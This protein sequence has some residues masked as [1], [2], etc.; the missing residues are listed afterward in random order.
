MA[1]AADDRVKRARYERN[2]TLPRALPAD[3]ENNVFFSLDDDARIIDDL[4]KKHIFVFIRAGVAAGKTTMA[5]YLCRKFKQ[6][7][8]VE[9]PKLNHHL[10]ASWIMS[11]CNAHKKQFPDDQIS[12]TSP[13][14][15]DQVLNS[16]SR[17]QMTLVFDEAHLFFQIKC[18]SIA[19]ALFKTSTSTMGIRVL[20]FSTTGGRNNG[21]GYF[22]PPEIQTRLLWS[23]KI[24]ESDDVVNQ[25]QRC[26]I[27]LDKKSIEFIFNFCGGN[28]GITVKAFTWVETKQESTSWD[29]KTTV[30]NI[31]ASATQGWTSSDFLLA[32]SKSRAVKVNSKYS[33]MSNI[34]K[35]FI[36]VLFQGPRT[37]LDGETLKNLTIA[38]FILPSPF[39]RNGPIS[40]A[41]QGRFIECN[42]WDSREVPFGVS[43]P[44]MAD[45]YR[46]KFA[47]SYVALIDPLYK[48]PQNCLDILVRVVPF[49][50]FKNLFVGHVCM[51][52]KN[53]VSGKVPSKKVPDMSA[54]VFPHETSYGIAIRDQLKKF[55]F[56]LHN[57][58]GVDGQPDIVVTSAQNDQTYII[59]LALAFKKISSIQA[60]LR[61]HL[62]RFCK[63]VNYQDVEGS[64]AL[65]VIGPDEKTILTHLERL[66]KTKQSSE[67]TRIV[68]LVGLC[69]SPAYVSYK[70]YCEQPTGFK[71]LYIPVDYVAR[72]FCKKTQKL[73]CVMNLYERSLR[74]S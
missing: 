7:V 42:F 17:N 6:Y 11:L 16:F 59:E 68:E 14:A 70:V 32:L 53:V 47:N 66:K 22:T 31:C 2:L 43:H 61:D 54:N 48:T 46:S 29:E 73:M 12:S 58:V 33:E 38:G 4:C 35:S 23:P 44:L 50:S 9:A 74:V 13:R 56:S 51:K 55:H 36:K 19:D 21:T 26:G 27:K 20:L 25:L 40:K 67:Y 45:L 28:F 57:F 62:E 71:P 52:G 41:T 60:N 49:L 15:L 39:S 63:L 65:V 8:L 10:D 64:K 18:S 1:A 34:P 5:N 69:P 72:A 30:S 24:P 3:P 37:G